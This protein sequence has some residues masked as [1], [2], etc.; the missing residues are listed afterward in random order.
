MRGAPGGTRLPVRNCYCDLQAGLGAVAP[1]PFESTNTS[2]KFRKYLWHFRNSLVHPEGLGH[3]FKHLYVTSFLEL[4]DS[5]PRLAHFVRSGILVPPT[6]K[7]LSD[8]PTPSFWCTRRDSNP[9][10]QRPQRCVLSTKLRVQLN[11]HRRSWI[12]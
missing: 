8:K 3:A 11:Q 12:L 1:A 10:S 9:R 4:L 7:M 6:R 5:R 2:S